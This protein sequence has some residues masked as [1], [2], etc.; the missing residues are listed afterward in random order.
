MAIRRIYQ[1]REEILESQN[2]AVPHQFHRLLGSPKPTVIHTGVAC[3]FYMPEASVAWVKNDGSNQYVE[4]HWYR[5]NRG[6]AIDSVKLER[7]L[8]ARIT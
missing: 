6:T 5:S 4:Q 8:M 1:P 3:R 7:Y 2:H